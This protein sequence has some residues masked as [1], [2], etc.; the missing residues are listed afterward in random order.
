MRNIPKVLSNDNFDIEFESDDTLS[1]D[2][3]EEF[4]IYH[5]CACDM[6]IEDEEYSISCRHCG[7]TICA[8]CVLD[9]LILKR[10]KKINDKV[11]EIG[12]KCIKPNNS[13]SGHMMNDPDFFIIT[14]D[15]SNC[16]KTGMRLKHD[17]LLEFFLSEDIICR[18]ASIQFKDKNDIIYDDYV[19][20]I[21]KDKLNMYIQPIIINIFDDD[22]TD[23][24]DDTI[25]HIKPETITY[26]QELQEFNDRPLIHNNYNYKYKYKSS[27]D[28]FSI[29]SEL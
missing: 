13:L 24:H 8:S 2:T 12:V 29:N 16:K 6:T 20:I 17:L 7:A 27:D 28:D 1:S 25:H 22:D 10:P 11:L 19:L 4:N 26:L 23:P 5:C 15:C 9:R 21:T 18:P 3:D 14:T